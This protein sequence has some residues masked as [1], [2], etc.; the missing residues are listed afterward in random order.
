MDAQLA[1]DDGFRSQVERWQGVF[2]PLENGAT[3]LIASAKAY[4]AAV[5]SAE[6]NNGAALDAATPPYSELDAL[7][8]L[9][10]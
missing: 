5:Q 10:R 6:A 4:Q 9:A 3:A 7:E 2:A 1:T 8:G